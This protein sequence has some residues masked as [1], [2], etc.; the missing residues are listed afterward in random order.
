MS[1]WFEDEARFGQQGSLTQVWAPCGSRPTAV[2]QT[3][4][5]Y[6]YVLGAVCPETGQSSGMLAPYLNTAIVNVFL[7]RISRKLPPQSHGV[8][9][10]DQAG[11]HRAHTLEVPAN[12]SLI[13]LPP[14]SPELNP[15]ENGW[16]YH[17]SHYWA[18]RDYQ[19]Y[20]DLEERACQ[21]WQAIHSQP[22]LVRSIY[23][24]PY[25][26]AATP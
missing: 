7:E 14:Y 1:I 18:N 2:R 10:W 25:L 11:Y 16:H 4:Y 24:A 5:E 22:D 8:L 19:G 15:M 23:R 21:S 3:R 13:P 12:I 26:A 20:E 17:R 6:L 9:I